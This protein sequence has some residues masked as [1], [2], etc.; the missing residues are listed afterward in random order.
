MLDVMS[1]L[2][3]RQCL[4]FDPDPEH[5]YANLVEFFL[6]TIQPQI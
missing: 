1:S 2:E 6:C 5:E 4:I 3:M